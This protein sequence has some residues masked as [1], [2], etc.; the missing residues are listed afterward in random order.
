[1]VKVSSSWHTF[2]F[3]E[4]SD[5]GQRRFNHHF[6]FW[7]YLTRVAALLVERDAIGGVGMREHRID[8]PQ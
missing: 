3:S 7:F 5:K 1:M 6:W 4:I 8:G 2:K